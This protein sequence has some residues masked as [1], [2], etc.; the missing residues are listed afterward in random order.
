MFAIKFEVPGAPKYLSLYKGYLCS[1]VEAEECYLWQIRGI[2]LYYNGVPASTDSNGNINTGS[3][4]GPF[5]YT[6]NNCLVMGDKFI[7][8]SSSSDTIELSDTP[9]KIKIMPYQVRLGICNWGC[10]YPNGSKNLLQRGADDVLKFGSSIIKIYAGRKSTKTYDLG[11]PDTTS[12]RDLFKH[13]AYKYVFERFKTVV[14]V[15]FSTFKSDDKYWKSGFSVEDDE[16]EHSEF[17]E[18]IEYLISRLHIQPSLISSSRTGKVIGVY[19]KKN[20]AQ[21]KHPIV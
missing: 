19:Q 21:A 12:L 13:P 7:V 18:A 2:F 11:V 1:R 20:F 8:Q 6:M 3:P 9:V 4:F 17:A 16:R 15:A 14:I 5:I 10:A